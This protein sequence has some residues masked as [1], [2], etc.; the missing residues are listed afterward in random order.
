MKTTFLALALL[1]IAA[2]S[3]T[4]FFYS[5]TP[6]DPAFLSQMDAPGSVAERLGRPVKWIEVEFEDG[7]FKDFD[8]MNVSGELEPPWQEKFLSDN[9]TVAVALSDWGAV[10]DL[11]DSENLPIARSVIRRLPRDDL[12]YLQRFSHTKP[13]GSFRKYYNMIFF[14][15]NMVGLLDRSCRPLFVYEV[16]RLVALPQDAGKMV[17]NP[18]VK[19]CMEG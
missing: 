18:K 12:Y 19:D 15:M 3:T 11:K 9:D 14:N 6:D 16:I 5:K 13:D 7:F 1:T 17:G 8:Q 4:F 10:D 2:L